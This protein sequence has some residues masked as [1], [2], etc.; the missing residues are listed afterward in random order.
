MFIALHV[1]SGFAT[2]SVGVVSFSGRNSKL[3]D[4]FLHEYRPWDLESEKGLDRLSKELLEVPPDRPGV[5]TLAAASLSLSSCFRRKKNQMMP[6]AMTATPPMQPKT[7]PS[8]VG[9]LIPLSLL[10]LPEESVSPV[11]VGMT[12][13]VR[14]T[15]ST[16]VTCGEA[17]GAGVDEADDEA[18]SLAD[19]GVD[20]ALLLLL[21]LL[22][23][24]LVPAIKLA[25]TST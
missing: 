21:L 19:E 22:L 4:L 17:D 1:R 3:P 13:T 7:M 16:V 20:E 14:A 24:P 8:R 9:T 25:S 15:P 6:I 5:L 10:L 23:L 11:C 2:R 12:V 18:E